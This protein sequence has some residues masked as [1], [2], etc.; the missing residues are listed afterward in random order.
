[1]NLDVISCEVMTAT[2]YLA[3]AISSLVVVGLISYILRQEERALLIEKQLAISR[4]MQLSALLEP[5]RVQ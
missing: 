1:M 3:F 5:K 2:F 4:E